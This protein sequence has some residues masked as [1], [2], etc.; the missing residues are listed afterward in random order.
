MKK[1]LTIEDFL[2]KVAKDNGDGW[3]DSFAKMTT[4]L[5]WQKHLTQGKYIDNIIEATKAYAEQRE[6]KAFEAARKTKKSI[7]FGKKDKYPSFEEY[8]K[9]NPIK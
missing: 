4:S 8:K 6:R 7:H 2:D 9:Q 5:R 3:F 1:E